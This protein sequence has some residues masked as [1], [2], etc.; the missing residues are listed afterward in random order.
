M[1]LARRDHENCVLLYTDLDNLKQT[2][3]LLGHETGSQLIVETANLLRKA[4]RDSDIIAR[5]GGDEFTVL[6]IGSSPLKES[7][8]KI[9]LQRQIREF[10]AEP[11]RSFELSLSIGLLRFEPS[12]STL[13]DILQQADS[14]MYEDKKAKK[15]K[16][17]ALIRT[18]LTA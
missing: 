1:K 7:E 3:D 2:N 4:F 14:K 12:L 16:R 6:M 5:V 9:R 17:Q 8:I 18:S 13:E 11:K 10:N 15:L